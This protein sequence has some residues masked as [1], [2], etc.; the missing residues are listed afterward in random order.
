M[1]LYIDDIIRVVSNNGHLIIGVEEKI[2]EQSGILMK[3]QELNDRGLV[4]LLSIQIL[5]LES[6]NGDDTMKSNGYYVALVKKL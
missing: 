2:W 5:P 3:L 1:N 4:S 6:N